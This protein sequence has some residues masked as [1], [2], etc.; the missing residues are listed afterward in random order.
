[1]RN[2][3]V[4]LN[5]DVYPYEDL[6]I[7]YNENRFAVLYDMYAR[8]QES[9]YNRE[10]RPLLSPMEF[11]S[12]APIVVVDLSY[13]NETVKS[14]PIDVKISTELTS[15]SEMDTKVYCILI[16]DRLVEYTPLT[17]LVQRIV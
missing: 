13:Q 3:K 2:A 16:H 15:A 4:Y 17:G 12:K 5:S 8:F 7:K 9:Y 10:S 14:G 11:I 6:N 1:M